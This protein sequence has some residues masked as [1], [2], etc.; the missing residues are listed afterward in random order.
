MDYLN[1]I[2]YDKI[3]PYLKYIIPIGGLLLVCIFILFIFLSYAVLKFL[4]TSID[5]NNIFFYQFNKKCQNILKKYGKWKINKMYLIRQPFG[6]MVS[7]AFNLVTLF[8]YSRYIA[9]S[10]DN[11][12]YHPAFI[13]EVKRGDE[14]KFLLLEKNNCINICE[15]FLM[16]KA[17]DYKQIHIKG[18][19]LTLN[20][21]LEKTKKRM[22]DRAFF[23]WNIYKNNCQAFTKEILITMNRYSDDYKEFIFRDKIIKLHNPSEFSLHIVNCLFIVI[24]FIEKYILNSY[25]FY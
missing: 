4:Q 14:I 5:Y 8:Q 21:I 15:S 9:E 12:P 17:H 25:L 3:V 19:K 10:Q 16:N 1:S 18:N 7:F 20:K 23:N 24:N 13:L 6:K 22:G 11:Y 2:P